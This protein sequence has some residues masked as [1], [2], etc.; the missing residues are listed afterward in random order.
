[1][2]S[3]LLLLFVLV[4]LGGAIFAVL[5]ARGRAL[6]LKI[7]AGHGLAGIVL[8]V[9]LAFVDAAHP[10]NY[11]ANAAVVLFIL[12]ALGGLLLFTFRVLK[13]RLPL[14]V[15]LLHAA[16][17]LFAVGLLTAGWLKAAA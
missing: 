15:V 17:A 11:P 9:C 14:A 8:I 10:G 3:L 2:L 1:M 5:E 4:A 7:S 12:T 13:Q 16:F 6:P